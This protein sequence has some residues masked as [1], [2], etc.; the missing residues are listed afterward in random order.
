MTKSEVALDRSERA[1]CLS[2]ARAMYV[3]DMLEE[4]ALPRIGQLMRDGKIV[5]YV[6]ATPSPRTYREGTESELLYYLIRGRYV[7]LTPAERSRAYR[8]AKLSMPPR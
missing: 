3:A 1:R 2:E 4:K 5:L 7:T 8:A 6:Q